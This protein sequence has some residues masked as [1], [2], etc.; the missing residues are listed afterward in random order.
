MPEKVW[1][2][3]LLDACGAGASGDDRLYSTSRTEI[4]FDVLEDGYATR[5]PTPAR[6]ARSDQHL[7]WHARCEF[8]ADLR[9][10]V[11]GALRAGHS[12]EDHV[13]VRLLALGIAAPRNSR[14][15]AGHRKLEQCQ[16]P[17]S[18]R[19]GGRVQ[20]QPA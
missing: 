18:L 6:P 2:D 17:Y 13:L 10:R 9:P 19:Q 5:A 15:L 1:E 14:R 7:L 3:P 20:H 11:K 4:L 16:R 12:S 8:A